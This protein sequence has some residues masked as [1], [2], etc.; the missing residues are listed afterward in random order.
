M[1]VDEDFAKI[2]FEL[3]GNLNS[4]GQLKQ[5][6]NYLQQAKVIFENLNNI[7][8]LLCL[9]R[10]GIIYTNLGDVKNGLEALKSYQILAKEAC[11]LNPN[12][13]KDLKYFMAYSLEKMG[14]I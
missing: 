2:I 3:A 1:I 8:F 4:T 13:N 5:A 6:L 10:I 9:E 12:N 14:N 7:N 11:E